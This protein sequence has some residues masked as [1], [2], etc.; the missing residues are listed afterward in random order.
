AF[1]LPP[2]VIPVLFAARRV[3]ADGLDVTVRVG[4]DPHVAPCRRNHEFVDAV[5]GFDVVD[6][7]AVGVDIRK[8]AAPPNTSYA[9]ATDSASAQPHRDVVPLRSTSQTS[10]FNP[11]SAPGIRHPMDEIETGCCQRRQS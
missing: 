1:L 2:L 6:R 8:P 11:A 7:V 10:L 5:Q 3:G 9:G 4:A